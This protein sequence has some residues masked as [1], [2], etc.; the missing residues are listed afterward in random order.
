MKCA[1][2]IG[3]LC[4]VT[5][6]SCDIFGVHQQK[7]VDNS[8]I[9]LGKRVKQIQ[10]GD[11]IQQVERIYG[12]PEHIYRTISH[13]LWR[14]WFGYQYYRGEM[15]GVK[16]SLYSEE[17][18]FRDALSNSVVDWISIVA[19]SPIYYDTLF[20]PFKGTT[21]HGIGIGVNK[22]KVREG[23]G[24]PDSISTVTNRNRGPDQ[25]YFYC[26][27]VDGEQKEVEINFVKDSVNFIGFGH[28]V[29]FEEP[30]AKDCAWLDN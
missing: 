9:V 24:P 27:R 7:V 22:K 14:A 2:S 12:Q 3:L 21:K 20:T 11:S 26:V 25:R 30:E 29:P 1:L 23:L 19:K 28:H 6:T 10:L 15:A 16:L 17:N 8:D 5:I 18:R 4:V 13:G